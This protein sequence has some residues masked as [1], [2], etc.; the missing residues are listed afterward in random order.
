MTATYDFR[1]VALSIIIAV[2]A[3]YTA[4]DL[5]EQVT[6]ATERERKLWLAGGAIAMGSGIWSMHFIAM[7]AY[8]LPILVDYNSSIVSASLALAVVA[9]GLALYIVSR[10]PIDRLQF[11]TGGSCMGLTIAGMHYT[12]M[13]GLQLEA[14]TEYDL[15]LVALSVM[16]AIGA[17]FAALLLA[18]QLRSQTT[19]TFTQV[20]HRPTRAVAT[21]EDNAWQGVNQGSQ[22]S[23][24]LR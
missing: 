20:S 24:T 16:I 12:G 6:A 21:A 4:L 9:S 13:A 19:S 11:L 8:K 5:A 17:S 3:S 7:L 15:A 10:Q 2:I 23:L 14:R 1:L 18:F 22:S